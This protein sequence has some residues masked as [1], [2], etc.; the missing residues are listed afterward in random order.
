VTRHRTLSAGICGF[1][2]NLIKSVANIFFKSKVEHL[3]EKE[4]QSV[5]STFIS[6]DA[7]HIISTIPLEIPLPFKAPFNIA[8]IIFSLTEQPTFA[9][10]YIGIGVAGDIVN[11][12][13]K[14]PAPFPAP[15]IPAFSNSSSAHFMQLF[16]SPYVIESAIWTYQQ[17]G[18]VD[19]T[20]KHTIVPAS[21]PIQLDTTALALVA[22]GIAAKF[23]N[24]W[25]DMRL[26]M[27]EGH[28]ATVGVT[29]A[30]GVSI[31]V[32]LH[33]EF[34]PVSDAGASQNA[35]TLGCNFTGA[36]AL[37]ANVNSTTGFPMIQGAL[38]YLECPLSVV[39]SN[40]GAVDAGLAKGL[41]DFV[42]HDAI[43]PLVNVLLGVGIPLPSM[44]GVNLRDVRLINGNGYMLLAT[45]FTYHPTLA[46][47]RI[48]YGRPLLGAPAPSSLRGGA[49]QLLDFAPLSTD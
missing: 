23:P 47:E 40:V 44:G 5:L 28:K 10:G 43:T 16:L 3:V 36:M 12:K 42:L 15:T 48:V 26:V 30:K 38:S 8:D 6:N 13:T 39:G 4:V 7:N 24:E 1:V 20:V 46:H 17:A 27:P 45:D 21:F 33:L 35:F 19:Y 9:P 49:P 14:A 34:N 22:P 32:P 37:H 11:S 41:V 31:S 18:L 2:A 25:V 29:P